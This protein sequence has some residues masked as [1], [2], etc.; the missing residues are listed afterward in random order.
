MLVSSK[1]I[2]VWRALPAKHQFT[3]ASRKIPP[4]E[5]LRGEG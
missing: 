2:G 5:V 4:E 1:K 3:A